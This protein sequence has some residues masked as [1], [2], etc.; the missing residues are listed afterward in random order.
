MSLSGFTEKKKKTKKTAEPPIEE[1]ETSSLPD[2][3]IVFNMG[4][5]SAEP[6]EKIRTI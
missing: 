5:G 6:K 3:P 1:E 2:F 4:E